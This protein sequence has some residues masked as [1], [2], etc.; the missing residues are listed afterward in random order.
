MVSVRLREDKLSTHLVDPY[1]LSRFIALHCSQF[2]GQN[3]SKLVKYHVVED[4]HKTE[5]LPLKYDSDNSPRPDL[6]RG[7]IIGDAQREIILDWLLEHHPDVV[8]HDMEGVPDARTTALLS[9]GRF[10]EDYGLEGGVIPVHTLDEKGEDTPRS[11]F[12]FDSNDV[13]P[14]ER[15]T[16]EDWEPIAKVLQLTGEPRWYLKLIC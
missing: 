10:A 14:Q 4:I 15:Y 11:I 5:G 6:L 1:R 16:K 13:V 3:L 2:I 9:A 12:F 8:C 7:W